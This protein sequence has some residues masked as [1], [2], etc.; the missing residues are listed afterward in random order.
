MDIQGCHN[1]EGS[2]DGQAKSPGTN[3]LSGRETGETWYSLMTKQELQSGDTMTTGQNLIYHLEFSALLA[4][5]QQ[6]GWPDYR[7]HQIWRWLYVA[8][9][10]RWDAM[11]N[12]SKAVRD[13][14]SACFNLTPP[15]VLHTDEK[16]DGVAKWLV[17]LSDG[18]RIEQVFIPARDRLTLCVSCQVG[19]KFHCTFCA[20]GQGGFVRHLTTGEIV[21]EVLLSFRYGQER[22]DNIVFMGMG[23]PFDNYDSVLSAIRIINDGTGLNIGAR[24]I[25]ISTCGVVPGIRKLAH[26]GLQVELSVSLHAPDDALRSALMPVNRRYSLDELFDACRFYT[27]TTNRIITFEYTMINGVNDSLAQ[28]HR[29]SDRVKSVDGRINLIALNAIDGYSEKP[30]PMETIKK[31]CDVLEK[32]G[33]NTTVRASKGSSLQ[34][35]CGQLRLKT[36]RSDQ[37][38]RDV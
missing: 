33:I 16:A 10:D 29:L 26:E 21:Q 24:H 28:A 25:T 36:Q 34:A 1:R 18:E 38:S 30:P 19:C 5:C 7:A 27:Q 22:P 17:E 9:V 14:L 12:L 23:E 37:K 35:A 3:K 8:H 31:F 6:C 13:Q 11:T 2:A 4:W 15:A 20:S 32:K